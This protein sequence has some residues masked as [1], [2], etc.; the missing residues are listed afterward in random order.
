MF[1]CFCLGFILVGMVSHS[2]SKDLNILCHENEKN[3]NQ[4]RDFTK[5]DQLD[6]MTKV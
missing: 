1:Q 4:R 6:S 5:T 2:Q 3:C